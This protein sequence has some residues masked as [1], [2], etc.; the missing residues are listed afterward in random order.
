[1][2][3]LKV[4]L[5]LLSIIT[6]MSAA[7]A[8]TPQAILQ[9]EV[10]LIPGDQPN[11]LC[12]AELDTVTRQQLTQDCALIGQVKATP[13]ALSQ[14]IVQIVWTGVQLKDKKRRHGY[15]N[16]PL[17]STFKTKHGSLFRGTTLELEGDT[18]EIARTLARLE[19]TSRARG[20][21]RNPIK[22]ERR[23]DGQRLAV[24]GQ[25]TAHQENDDQGEGQPSVALEGAGHQ[26]Q[27]KS[28]SSDMSSTSRGQS[29]SS[30]GYTSLSST[31]A[32]APRQRQHRS[33]QR[34]SGVPPV[35]TTPQVTSAP[36][37]H[38]HT[39]AAVPSMSSSSTGDVPSASVAGTQGMP[40]SS[41]QSSKHGLAAA[42]VPSDRAALSANTRTGAR[43]VV[44]KDSGPDHDDEDDLA[45]SMIDAD[46][47]SA[48]GA[49]PSIGRDRDLTTSQGKNPFAINHEPSEALKLEAHQ[50]IDVEITTQGCT[51]R[52]DFDKN[53]YV[54][55]NRSLTR[56]GGKIIEESPCSDSTLWYAIKRDYS[57]CTDEVDRGK[58]V[59]YTRFRR[60][61]CDDDKKTKHYLDTTCVRDESQPHPF[62]DDPQ[63]C[64]HHIDLTLNKAWSQVE[65]LYVNRDHARI[66]VDRCHKVGS[67]L[68]IIETAKGCP[69]KHLFERNYSVVQKRSIFIDQGVE[70]TV[71]LCHESADK[72]NH[73]FV[74]SDCKPVIQGNT[75]VPMAK[76]QVE[77]Q[78]KKLLITSACEP[79][80]K[81]NLQETTEGCEGQ[82]YDDF[83]AGRSYQAVRYYYLWNMKKQFVTACQRSTIFYPHE[84]QFLGY[85]NF[86]EILKAKPRMLI[87][88]TVNGKTVPLRTLVET[89]PAK[90]FPYTSI[91]TSSRVI[92]SDPNH[93]AY[94]SFTTWKR[95]DGST[96]DQAG[97]TWHIDHPV[98]S[99]GSSYEPYNDHSSSTY[100][101]Q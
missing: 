25:T 66:I 67:A 95:P 94:Q 46:L 70:H 26:P 41:T 60:Y 80:D 63:N 53:Q 35:I 48:E 29:A 34:N 85:Q 16:K 19:E 89:N 77:V 43:A 2:N 9:Q 7:Y 79:M 44:D 90:F 86:D 30:G 17:I 12:R 68:P 49:S 13:T 75:V 99:S 42:A 1:M 21:D 24:T 31:K 74:K 59:A 82:Y 72:I 61:W 84:V 38:V 10:T 36:Q 8:K 20:L 27:S 52:V 78:G 5:I 45:H 58:R 50:P 71:V 96:Y 88:V 23:V 51:P 11:S 6:A 33:L 18:Q 32:T 64:T 15:F 92:S 100:G 4:S 76:R 55:Q 73:T 81:Q 62:I 3:I 39:A 87:T 22:D 56:Q 40:E 97:N 98:V 69:L 65:T 54:I 83:N 14:Q 101:G 37:T 93:T 91:G 57:V 28:L 47:S